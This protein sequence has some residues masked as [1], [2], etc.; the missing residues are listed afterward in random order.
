MIDIISGTSAGG[1]NGIYLAK[2]L[3]GNSEITPVQELWFDEGDIAELIN[4]KRSYD[5]IPVAYTNETESLLNSRRMYYRLLKAFDAMD[6]SRTKPS[7]DIATTQLADEIDVFATTTDIEGIP[8]PI[9]LLDNIV[10]ERRHRNDF[11]L[12]FVPGERNDFQADNNPFLAFAARCTSSF[13]FTFEPMRLCDIDEILRFDPI[14]AQ[15]KKYCRSESTRWRKFFM[16]YLEFNPEGQDAIYAGSTPFRERSFGDGGYLNNAPFSFAVNSLLALQ[17]MVPIDRKLLYVEPSPSHPEEAPPRTEKPDAV[18]NSLA[19]LVTIPGYQ[20]IRD[21]LGRMLERNDNA[22]KI[23]KALREV[24]GTIQLPDLAPG[25]L[26]DVGMEQ[27]ASYRGY[28]QIRATDTTGM[29]ALMV[30]Q[31]LSIDE[32]SIHFVALRSLIRAWRERKYREGHVGES[33]LQRF[34]RRFDIAYRVRRLRFVLRKLD[35][36]YALQLDPDHPA[37]A[38]AI[39]M[40]RFAL[41]I[42]ETAAMAKHGPPSDLGEIWSVI[43]DQ[44]DQLR[45]IARKL[46][47]KPLPVDE[48]TPKAALF[49]PPA[50]DPVDAIRNLLLPLREQIFS[51]LSRVAGIDFGIATDQAGGYRLV[52]RPLNR[53]ADVSKLTELACDQEANRSLRDDAQLQAALEEL[54]EQLAGILAPAFKT[55]HAAAVTAFS[56]PDPGREAGRI[57]A[58]LYQGFD[59]FDSVQFPMSFGTDIGEPDEVDIIRISPEDASRLVPDVRTRRAKLKGLVAAHFGAFFDRDWR[60]SDLLWGRLDAAERIIT[61]LLPHAESVVLRDRLIDQAQHAILREF[62]VSRRFNDMAAARCV[63]RPGA[64]ATPVTTQTILKQ[65]AGIPIGRTMQEHRTFMETW[66][67]VLPTEPNRVMLLQTLARGSQTVG[68]ML[69]GIAGRRN[70]PPW[71][72]WITNVGRALWSVVEISIPQRLGA[73]FGRYLQSLLLL[74]SLVLI[75]AGILGAQSGVAAVGWILFL[76]TIWLFLARASLARFLRGANVLG[77]LATIGAVVGTIVL[78]AGGWQLY[79]WGTDLLDRLHQLGY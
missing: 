53:S 59:L 56:A 36:S 51:V 66:M 57:A 73:L 29:L 79:S 55:A 75:V 64:P 69:D 48:D 45:K 35:S 74:I 23:N 58:R 46:T 7:T 68:R 19:A 31:T 34:L 50:G 71:G 67:K 15:N 65:I 26:P 5:Q 61:A 13:P 28:Y 78:V 38:A 42:D 76:A 33:G 8:V 21:D 18:E 37:H 6:K 49:V 27:G 17:P 40:L 72:S 32:Q 4:D 3:V 62:D 77:L 16:N 24:E 47:E 10:Y 1:I 20:T 60:I 11:H 25:D 54:D 41:S 44:Y 12:R 14:Y 39:G 30:A 70:L 9:R 43:A 52:T 22:A 63:P 2:A